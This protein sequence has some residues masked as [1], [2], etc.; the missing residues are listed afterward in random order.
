MDDQEGNNKYERFKYNYV[1]FLRNL[2]SKC[3]KTNWIFKKNKRKIFNYLTIKILYAQKTTKFI[4]G[5]GEF[6]LVFNFI[7]SFIFLDLFHIS[8]Q[9]LIYIALLLILSSSQALMKLT[10][11]VAIRWFTNI[12][13]NYLQNL[14][15]NWLSGDHIPL[16]LSGLLFLMTKLSLYKLSK[17]LFLELFFISL[18]SITILIKLFSPLFS[19]QFLHL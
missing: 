18:S 19:F 9:D 2:C 7:N 6:W 4:R 1:L 12:K 14:R 5:I 11:I 13:F 3:K 16:F 8:H 17:L 10:L 15:T